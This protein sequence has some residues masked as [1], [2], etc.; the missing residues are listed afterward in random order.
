M[1]SNDVWLGLPYDVFCFTSIQCL[2]SEE[3]GIPLGWYQHQV[4]SLHVYDANKAKT[5]RSLESDYQISE[6][7]LPLNLRLGRSLVSAFKTTTQQPNDAPKDL[8]PFIQ[9]L[10][11]CCAHRLNP[12]LPKSKLRNWIELSERD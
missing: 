3:I 1:R 7:S 11:D 2:I 9:P 4:G 8:D 12:E 5:Q 6:A 10:I